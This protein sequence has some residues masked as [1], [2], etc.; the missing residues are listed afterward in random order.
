ML[1][2]IPL[3]TPV[4]NGNE[5]N[6]SIEALDS[7]QISTAGKFIN[8]FEEEI[9]KRIGGF[10]VAVTNSGTSAIHL[11]LRLLGVGSGDEVLCQSFTFCASAIPIQYLGAKPIFVD[12]ESTT[13]NICPEILEESILERIKKGKKPKAIVVVDLFGMPAKFKEI[14]VIAAKYGIPIV[15]DAAEALGSAIDG[16][17]SGTFGEFG[18]YSFNGNKIITTGSGG[19]LVSTDSNAIEKAKYLSV[20]ARENYKYYLHKEI[21]YNYRMNNMAAAIGLAQIQNLDRKIS[22]RRNIFEN[23]KRLLLDIPGISTIHE[24]DGFYSNRWL[25]TFLINKLET[26]ISIEDL[27]L[28]LIKENIES[29]YLW[30]PL[31]LQPV[32][33]DVPFYG[34]GSSEK[35]FG[36]GICLPSS[37]NLTMT[38]QERIVEIIVKTLSKR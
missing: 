24:P 11:A 20:Q 1:K 17:A 25:S 30:N 21:G 19:A 22:F 6:F 28:A 16:K 15:E 2:S 27:R 10:E 18:I 35:L 34:G 8:E 37:E 36:E 4:F 9:K 23:Y 13:W 7:N 32:F 26:G 29:R 14:N 33:K 38:D 3:S 12:S 31:H 5:N